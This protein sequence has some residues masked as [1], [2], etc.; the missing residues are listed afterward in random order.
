MPGEI[1]IEI[2]I[3]KTLII[4]QGATL[5]WSWQARKMLLHKVKRT[6]R[7]TQHHQKKSL[8]LTIVIN[9]EQL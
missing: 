5:L 2:Q 8:T 1:Q 9:I 4:P 6:I 7:Q 3:K